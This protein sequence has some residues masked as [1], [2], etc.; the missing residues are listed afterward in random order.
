MDTTMTETLPTRQPLPITGYTATY[1]VRSGSADEWTKDAILVFTR[2]DDDSLVAAYRAQFPGSGTAAA[3]E[4]LEFRG[5]PRDH[6][7][8][9]VDAATA[10]RAAIIGRL[11]GLPVDDSGYAKAK[12]EGTAASHWFS[13]A[14]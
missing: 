1:P 9:I 2:N 8:R 7:T 11:A 13:E 3:I 10:D 5:C 4:W 14:E 6:A 12:C